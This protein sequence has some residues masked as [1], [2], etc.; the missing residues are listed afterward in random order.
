MEAIQRMIR[1]NLFERV[2][3]QRNLVTV[4]LVLGI[5]GLLA[6]IA[7]WLLPN[8]L[9]G[10]HLLGLSYSCGLVGILAVGQTIVILTGG[11]DI[12]IGTVM[13]LSSLI[14]VE[15][16]MNG[17]SHLLAVL[18]PLA[19]G[20]GIGSISG[21]GVGFFNVSPIVMTLGAMIAIGGGIL[22][23]SEGFTAGRAPEDFV[24]FVLGRKLFLPNI[25][26]YWLIVSAVFTVLLRATVWGRHVQAVGSNPTSARRTGINVPLIITSVYMVSGTLGSLAGVLML[27]YL[28]Q[29]ATIGG[30]I[31]VDQSM[32]S[33]AAAVLGGTAFYGARGGIENSV[34]GT[35][36]IRSR[37][38]IF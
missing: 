6:L 24:N 15:L 2:S 21:I 27:G 35:L 22:V 26:I 31:G 3:E 25:T 7:G 38:T 36:L 14:C 28:G 16:I 10:P 33:I 20:A 34:A 17:Y 37:E 5:T 30:L 32:E 19:I 4:I 9:S 23:Y 11:I 29:C 18:I 1:P 8:Y 12:A 13:V